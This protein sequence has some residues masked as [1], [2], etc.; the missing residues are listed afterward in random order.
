MQYRVRNWSE[1]NAGLKQRGSLTIWLSEDALKQWLVTTPTGRRGASKTYSDTAIAT[2]A[3]LKSL[4]HLA[5]AYL[6]PDVK[7][8]A[9]WNRCFS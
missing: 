8:R 2:V 6:Q 9:L 1:Y 7:L 3:T 4:F 5:G